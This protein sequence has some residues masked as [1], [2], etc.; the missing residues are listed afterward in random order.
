ME[1][2]TYFGKCPITF[3]HVNLMQAL[4]VGIKFGYYLRKYIEVNSLI[5]PS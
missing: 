1:K 2:H 4:K 3:H 5:D